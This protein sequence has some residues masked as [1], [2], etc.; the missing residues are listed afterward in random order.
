MFSA[1]PLFS[2]GNF[3]LYH[4]RCS[5]SSKTRWEISPLYPVSLFFCMKGGKASLES[6]GTVLSNSF[7]AQNKSNFLYHDKNSATLS[8][9]QPATVEFIEV[10]LKKEYLTALLAQEPKHWNSYFHF[11]GERQLLLAEKPL[12]FQKAFTH[13]I[14]SIL[15]ASVKSIFLKEVVFEAKALELIAVFLNQFQQPAAYAQVREAHSK[16]AMLAKKRIDA[17]KGKKDFTIISL[18]HSL[19][20][21]E[22]TLKQAFKAVYGK[23]IF[24]YFQEKNL[25]MAKEA[26]ESGTSIADI[27]ARCGYSYI[28]HF[29]IAF[30]KEFGVPPSKFK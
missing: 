19:K 1:T 30:K 10:R 4:A 21:N 7:L 24:R 8:W 28:S 6:K 20:T 23:T 29:S 22:T 14:N 11:P 17:Q 13:I 26:L 15:N 16:L 25:Q 5:S 9:Q 27:T 18:A 2:N 12:A 3:Q